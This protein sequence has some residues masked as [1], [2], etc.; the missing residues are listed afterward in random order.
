MGGPR[1]RWGG[2][3]KRAVVGSVLA[4]LI[5]W[6]PALG[7]A[8]ASPSREACPPITTLSFVDEAVGAAVD[9]DEHEK[10]LVF[11]TQ[12]GRQLVGP[13][14]RRVGKRKVNIT[15]RTRGLSIVLQADLVRG[16]ARG[17]AVERDEETG[18]PQRFHRLFVAHGGT[19][20]GPC[21][22]VGPVRPPV[23]APRRPEATPTPRPRPA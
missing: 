16:S 15:A 13:N 23:A 20:L 2:V 8:A 1:W 14:A 22:A 11:T 17:S 9:Y 6:A 18:A 10:L 5:A 4:G 19:K 3:V 21:R 12:D 7:A